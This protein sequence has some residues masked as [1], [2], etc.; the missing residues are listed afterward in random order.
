MTNLTDKEIVAISSDYIKAF[1]IFDKI[2]QQ[3]ASQ[4][5]LIKHFIEFEKFKE[6]VKEKIKK[7]SRFS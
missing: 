5:A 3:N 2:K 4:S 7:D 6:V 1:V